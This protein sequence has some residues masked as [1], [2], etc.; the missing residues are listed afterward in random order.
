MR[1]SMKEVRRA[2]QWIYDEGQRVGL[3]RGVGRQLFAEDH[4]IPEGR[5]NG[6]RNRRFSAPIN[7]GDE[8]GSC[9]FHPLQVAQRARRLPDDGACFTGCLDANVQRIFYERNVAAYNVSIRLQRIPH[10]R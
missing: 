7:F 9:F 4:G 1:E 3:E 5:M 6:G 10:T 8:I 2:I